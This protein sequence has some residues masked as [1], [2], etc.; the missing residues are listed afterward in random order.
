MKKK[1]ERFEI[2]LDIWQ[3][4]TIREDYNRDMM[5]RSLNEAKTPC[6][7][8][9]LFLHEIPYYSAITQPISNNYIALFRENIVEKN[10]R[11]KFCNFKYT[12]NIYGCKKGKKTILSFS[13]FEFIA[14]H[15]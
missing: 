7:F 14:T 9:P 11:A 1:H 6:N 2:T 13:Y 8:F 5:A 12:K 3:H 15:R 10:S 4:G